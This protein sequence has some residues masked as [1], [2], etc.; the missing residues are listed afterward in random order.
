M[1]QIKN[2]EEF[3]NKVIDEIN[4]VRKDPQ[5]Y[6]NKIRKYTTY[7]KGKILKVPELT[8]IITSEGSK[9]FE[10]AAKVLDN[11]DS[12]NELKYS[13]GLTHTAHDA[14]KEIQKFD[15]VDKMG[16]LNIDS[17]IS[18]YGEVQ[19]VF[20]Q[21]CDFG[22][23]IPE[24]VVINLLVDDGDP[25][26]GNRENIISPT[27]RLI[28]VSTGSHNVYNSCTVVMFA[29]HFY[30]KGEKPSKDSDD[31]EEEKRA[32]ERK[33]EEINE[34]SSKLNVVR[35]TS[36]NKKEVDVVSEKLEKTAISKILNKPLESSQA[37]DEEDF[38]LPAGCVKLEKQE[39]IVTENGVKKKIVKLTKHME[40]GTIETEIFKEKI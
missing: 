8:P 38:D 7:F 22:S 13:P 14:L 4:F 40:N 19:G 16:D 23:P 3:R 11:L 31:E 33:K 37:A 24:M 20:A 28:G 34:I 30:A 9:A 29:K 10:E 5:S 2:T 1:E 27:F 15:D 26:R 25:N 21:A 32:V 6:A 18:K 39:K 12:L 17:F 36:L 35:R